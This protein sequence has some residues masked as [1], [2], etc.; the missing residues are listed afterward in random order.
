MTKQLKAQ[1]ASIKDYGK[2]F[3]VM[4]GTKQSAMSNDIGISFICALDAVVAIV[5]IGN[6]L[7][8]L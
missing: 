7:D 2:Y 1:S 8:F 3:H 5:V 6:V 4:L